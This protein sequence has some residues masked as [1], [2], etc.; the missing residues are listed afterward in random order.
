MTSEI[1]KPSKYKAIGQIT[2]ELG[3]VDKKTGSLQTHT[4]R[5]WE[6]QFRQIK[7]SLRAGKRRY[8]SDKDFKI[9]KHIK[10]LLRDKGFTINGVK[11][12]LESKNDQSIDQS[13]SMGVYNPVLKSNTIIKRVKNISKIIKE[14]KKI[15]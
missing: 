5:Y 14:L 11:K 10:F 8:Y 7:P 15:K 1:E 4:L 3:L 6:S 2:K 13:T 9:I 12:L